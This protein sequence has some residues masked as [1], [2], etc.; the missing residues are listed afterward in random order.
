M[1][2]SALALVLV[3]LASRAAA[4]TITFDEIANELGAV[5]SWTEDGITATGKIAYYGTPGAVHLDTEGT[6][7]FGGHIDIT[8]GG[9]FLPESIDVIGLSSGYCLIGS[10]GQ[11]ES[12]VGVPFDYIY[13]GGYIDGQ[14]VAFEDYFAQGPETILLASFPAVDRLRIRVQPY[15]ELGLPGGCDLGSGCGHFDLDA[16]TVAPIPE[17]RSWALAFIGTA[18]LVAVRFSRT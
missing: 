4:A 11:C 2:R 18:V 17:P 1:L 9:L 5:P 6:T 10:L 13:V 14:L 3:L 16:V 15:Y 12:E 7:Q 8:T